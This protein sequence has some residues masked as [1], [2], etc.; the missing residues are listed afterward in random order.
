[1]LFAWFNS[2]PVPSLTL[3]RPVHCLTDAGTVC[4]TPSAEVSL[5]CE[6]AAEV[7]SPSLRIL[8]EQPADCDRER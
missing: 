1:M 7:Q 6:S 4:G 3:L 8:G 5:G 2:E